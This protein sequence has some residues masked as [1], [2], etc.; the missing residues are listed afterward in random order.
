MPSPVFREVGMRL[1][2]CLVWALLIVIVDA[3]AFAVPLAALVVA[4]V[5][6]ARPAWF[7]GEHRRGWTR[8]AGGRLARP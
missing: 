6:L 1:T 3:V 7:R 4:Y 5:V 2:E 8:E